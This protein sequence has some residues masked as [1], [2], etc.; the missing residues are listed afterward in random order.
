MRY[1]IYVA[2]EELWEA[3]PALLSEDFYEA[4]VL[5]MIAALSIALSFF[6][7]IYMYRMTLINLDQ[8]DFFHVKDQ[9]TYDKIIND[10]QYKHWKDNRAVKVG[11]RTID[12]RLTSFELDQLITHFGP[13]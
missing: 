9:E 8:C 7:D 1:D 2:E 5:W 12:R 3:N 10:K 13:I 6:Y 11:G 4:D